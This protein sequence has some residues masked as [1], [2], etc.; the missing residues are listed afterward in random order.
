M[1]NLRSSVYGW[2]SVWMDL[3]EESQGKFVEEQSQFKVRV[4]MN[5]WT[6]T[7][8]MH[9]KSG[10]ADKDE[11][12]I[13]LPF[14]SKFD[15]SFAIYPQTKIAEVQKHFG[16]QDII[17]GYPE[18]DSQFIVKGNDENKV[19]KLFASDNLRELIELQKSVRLS[20]LK[21]AELKPYGNVPNGVNI[22][23]FEEEG[24]INSFDR[25]VSLIE[26]MR[27][28]MSQ[29]SELGVAS[30]KDPNFEI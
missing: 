30:E 2:K 23:L 17:V 14:I 19:R 15:F 4:P 20:I 27:A 22:L 24:A 26:L 11:T 18:F 7:F 21:G 1:P 10:M 12:K 5:P 16:L 13:L 6:V 29:L 9:S 3:A 8:Q 25:L 28:A